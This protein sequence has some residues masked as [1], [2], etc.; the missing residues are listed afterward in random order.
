MLRS[1][2]DR[3]AIESLFVFTDYSWLQYEEVIRPLGDDV[4]VQAAP[5]SGWP[6]LRDPLTH[7][8]WAYIRWLERPTATTEEPAQRIESWDEL[9]EHRCR[10]R[11]H[12][13]GYLDSLGDDELV[14]PRDMDVDGDTLLY[15]PADIFVHTLLHERQHHGDLNTLLYQLGVEAPIV[16][17]RFSLPERPTEVGDE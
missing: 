15:S 10:V 4:L 3:A 7:I 5:G 1:T 11:D 12:A 17:Y 8:N 6:A 2:M 13:R 14:T 9:D 16:E